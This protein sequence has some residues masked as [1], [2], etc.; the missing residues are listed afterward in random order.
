[1]QILVYL[2]NLF[3]CCF[4]FSS[5]N[6]EWECFKLIGIFFSKLGKHLVP[7]TGPSFV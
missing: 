3:V 6:W 5:D 7:E 1:M 2:L 4:F